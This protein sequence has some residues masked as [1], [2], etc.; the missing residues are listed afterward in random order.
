[1]EWLQQEEFQRRFDKN[2]CPKNIYLIDSLV[3]EVSFSELNGILPISLSSHINEEDGLGFRNKWFGSIDDL[4]FTVTCL[5]DDFIYLCLREKDDITEK[6]QWSFLEKLVGLPP[7]ILNRISWIRT[8]FRVNRDFKGKAKSAV[9]SK[10]EHGIAFQIYKAV[11]EIE[12]Q[13]LL[14][15]LGGLN[16]ECNYWIDKPEPINQTWVI[17]KSSTNEDD[18]IAGRY[19][20]RTVA[21]EVARL[22]STSDNNFYRVQEENTGQNGLTF[23]KGTISE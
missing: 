6:Y 16:S 17:T 13:E 4:L 8:D 7:R 15:F 20:R 1:M 11:S 5:S 14:N 3:S 22:N 12:T 21:E 2:Y 23:F 10:T 18:K 19:T 9:F